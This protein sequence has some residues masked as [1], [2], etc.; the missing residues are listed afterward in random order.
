MKRHVAILCAIL[1]VGLVSC[2]KPPKAE[3]D[4]AT[5][6]VNS[7]AQSADVLAW[8]PEALQKARGLL[9][10]MNAEAAAKR[11]DKAKALAADA[12]AA[13][14]AA[15]TEAQANLER[16][17]TKASETIAAVKKALPETEKILAGAANVKKALLD[18]AAQRKAFTDAKSALA[19]A[20]TAF[21]SADYQKA[22]DRA[23]AAQKALADI[24]AAISTAVQ[25][26]TRKK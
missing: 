21:A 2:A 5:A 10:Q 25:A 11:Y 12:T 1:A 17:K 14:N 13:A 26:A 4:A 6:A 15:K 20:E 8:A 16:G 7:A 19:E 9:D 23:G 24:N 22:L 3:M 18:L